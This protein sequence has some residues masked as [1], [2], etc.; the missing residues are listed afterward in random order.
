[1]QLVKAAT[2]KGGDG[3]DVLPEGWQASLSNFFETIPSSPWCNP[4]LVL[5]RGK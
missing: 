3:L 2:Q 4:I 5:A 1:L